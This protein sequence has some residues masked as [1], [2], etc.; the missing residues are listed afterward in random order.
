VD[1]LPDICAAPE[2]NDRSVSEIEPIGPLEFA[3]I[4]FAVGSMSFAALGCLRHLD[5]ALGGIG[6]LGGSDDAWQPFVVNLLM[7]RNNALLILLSLFACAIDARERWRA[8]FALIALCVVALQVG[9]GIL[10][11]VLGLKREW[12]NSAYFAGSLAT[13]VCFGW[14][15]VNSVRNRSGV[16]VGIA[17]LIAMPL[18]PI[19][20]TGNRTVA[21]C[22]VAALPNCLDRLTAPIVACGL[23]ALEHLATPGFTLGIPWTLAAVWLVVRGWRLAS[24]WP[25]GSGERAALRAGLFLVSVSVLLEQMQFLQQALVAK[26][27]VPGTPFADMAWLAT[28]HGLA[29]IVAATLLRDVPSINVTAKRMRV[30]VAIWLVAGLGV[31]FWQGPGAL[32]TASMLVAVLAMGMLLAWA[33]GARLGMNCSHEG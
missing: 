1:P 8:K 24:S 12:T 19:D 14:A 17:M 23:F 6:G 11:A 13:V 7:A 21:L 16:A 2:S 28:F 10:S 29:M 20:P 27:R 15:T 31:V 4:L 9:V 32:P 22:V 33:V 30:V 5:K 18:L 26:S 25:V 3:A